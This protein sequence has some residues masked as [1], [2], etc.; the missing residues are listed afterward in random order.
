MA[1]DKVLVVDDEQHMLRLMEYN[2][3]EHG[4]EVVTVANGES[5]IKAAKVE[6]PSLILLDIKMPGM[7]G[8]E[9]YQALMA[10]ASTRGIPIIVVSILADEDKAKAI[11]ARS[12][13]LKPFSPDVLIREVEEVLGGGGANG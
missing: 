4:Y 8:V 10:D 7:N 5:A 1:A 13:I 11:G 12:Y 6:R 9:V 3:K 2:L